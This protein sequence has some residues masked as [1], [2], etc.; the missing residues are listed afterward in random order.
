VELEHISLLPAE[1][2]SKKKRSREL[3]IST[4]ALGIVAGIL[5]FALVILKILS[6]V[7]E[8]ELKALKSESKIL[9]NEIDDLLLLKTLSEE[10]KQQKKLLDKAIGNQP[11]WLEIFALVGAELP[12]NVNITNILANYTENSAK[13]DIQ[14]NAAGHDKVALWMKSL[15]STGFFSDI[16]LNYSRIENSNAIRFELEATIITKE[17]FKLFGEVVVK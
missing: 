1:F 15:K 7:P 2:K 6:V 13:L 11:D 10:V 17:K 9:Q 16:G 3:G 14:G 8:S 12:E 5:I 4:I